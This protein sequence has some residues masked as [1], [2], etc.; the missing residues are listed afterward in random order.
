MGTALVTST[1]VSAKT[2]NER[3]AIRSSLG[4]LEGDTATTAQHVG[5]VQQC[6]TKNDDEHR[7]EEQR[8]ERQQQF[9]RCFLCR[10][11]RALATFRAQAVRIDAYCAC[12]RSTEAIRLDQH[13][14]E[15]VE[16]LDTRAIS[17]V[18]QRFAA[19]ATHANFEVRE[20]EFL[21]DVG[22]DWAQ[23]FTNAKHRGVQ[24]QTCFHRDDHQVECIGEAPCDAQL[25]TGDQAIEDESR[26]Q[27]TGAECKKRR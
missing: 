16:I 7:R 3:F 19:L 25:A 11:F 8:S 24:A 12:D 2:I 21:A 10:L 5:N 13:A 1:S 14:D 6:W 17:E 4:D 18:S 22:M 26:Q 27:E 20:L 15:T 9:E 23:L